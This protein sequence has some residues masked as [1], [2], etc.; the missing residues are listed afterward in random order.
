MHVWGQGCIWEISASSFKFYCERKTALKKK[1]FK[2]IVANAACCFCL[3]QCLALNCLLNMN[4]YNIVNL[5]LRAF[6]Y[7]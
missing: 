4:E 5:K 3:A 2:K 1:G 6:S 7:I